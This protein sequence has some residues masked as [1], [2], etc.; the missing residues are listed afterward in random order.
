[1]RLPASA[2]AEAC[3]GELVGPDVAVEG[4]VND[5]RRLE[6]GQLFVPVV[7][8]RD[9]HDFIADALAAGASA[10]LT[11]RAPQGGT[12]IVVDDT[13]RAFLACGSVPRAMLPDRVVGITGSV[14]KTSTKDLT[15]AA[16]ATTFPT[17]ASPRN[18]NNELGLPITLLGAPTSTQALVLEMGARGIGHIAA[19][20]VVGRPTIGVVTC[21]A[22]VHTEV[23]GTI[24]DV[25]RGKRELV[26]ALPSSGTAVL[27]LDDQRV[28]AMRSHTQ[29][30]VLGYGA[31]PRADLHAE[32][33][34]VDDE[35]RASFTL[36][37]PWGAAPV[38]LSVRGAHQVAN[39]LAAA[40]AA[41]AA[42]APLES[43]AAG[44]GT[45]AKSPHRMDVRR[46]A[47]GAWIIDDTYNASPLSMAAALHS[48]V[49]LPAAGRHIAVLGPMA[50]LGTT[51]A[52]GHADVAAVAAALH[53]HVVAVGTTLYGLPPVDD[54]IAAIGPLS[55][56]DAILVKASRN[57]G[58]ETVAAALLEA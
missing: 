35:L 23:F 43:V 37:S 40:G 52:A 12:A 48:L 21:V 56:D 5:H 53:V 7:A 49:E 20:C 34:V 46:S 58:L 3:G 6:A 8:D 38:R 54:P 28:A 1:V 18:F 42:G 14:G 32:H 24:D 2:L 31:A 55:P 10:Y 25:A 26:E 19:L 11:S 51:E 36:R 27:N 30:R 4:A 29:A 15:A 13:V 47:S 41:L 9:G 39:A 16:L 44:L 57:A 33:V 45:E 50:E 22:G 17:H